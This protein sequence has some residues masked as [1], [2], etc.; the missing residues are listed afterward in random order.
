MGSPCRH[1]GGDEG[2]GGV[3][4]AISCGSDRSRVIPGIL[5]SE[6]GGGEVVS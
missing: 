6:I 2:E 3:R 5:A 1:R 4:D